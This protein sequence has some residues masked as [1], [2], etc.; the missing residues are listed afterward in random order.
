MLCTCPIPPGEMWGGIYADGRTLTQRP[1][2][3]RHSSILA[4]SGASFSLRLR[5]GLTLRFAGLRAGY[6]RMFWL[7]GH[8]V[9]SSVFP[10][11]P[12]AVLA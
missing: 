11:H 2:C 3:P 10:G 8:L 7:W 5:R 1:A 12:P 9:L 6:E 4:R